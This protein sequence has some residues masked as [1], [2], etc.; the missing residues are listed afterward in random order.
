MDFGT[1]KNKFTDSYI[2]SHI[3]E[4]EG[5]KQLYKKFLEVLKESETLKE[6]FIVYKNLETKTVSSE[7]EGIEYIKEN[8]SLL[9]KFRGKKSITKECVKLVN[10]LENN[11]ISI[12]GKPNLFNESLHILTTKKITSNNLDEIHE[13]KM[14]IVK[15]LMSD[16][17]VEG[18]D[19]DLV[20]ENL[21]TS[22]FLEI[23]TEKYNEKYSHLPEYEK[24]IVKVM[25]EGSY[26]E[27]VGLLN[28]LV[29]E[30]VGLVNKQLM[31]VG[32]NV[33]LKSKLLET[34]DFI[35]NTKNDL[36]EGDL[37]PNINKLYE[38]R[39]VLSK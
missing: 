2:S 26:S 24:N 16:K 36:N 32:D 20:R 21:D 35:Y 28:D 7:V 13:A 25:F 38:I 31:S 37:K 33:E 19:G 23:A 39:N 6:F 11:D 3:N 22:K 8:L 12:D 4:N 5:G 18:D 15:H 27:K 34:K 14:V 1:L 29:T 9:D 10:L 30:T 17:T